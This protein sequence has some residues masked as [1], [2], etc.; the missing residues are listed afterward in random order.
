MISIVCALLIVGGVFCLFVCC[1]VKD[2]DAPPLP[3]SG[4]PMP[5]T[6]TSASSGTAAS[7]K[8]YRQDLLISVEDQ[9]LHADPNLSGGAAAAMV[10]Q[11]TKKSWSP[12]VLEDKTVRKEIMITAKNGHV[13]LGDG[14]N[15]AATTAPC[16]SSSATADKLRRRSIEQH[17]A[18][19]KFDTPRKQIGAL[20]T[21]WRKDEK[22]EKSVRDK[23]A[24]FST[25]AAQLAAAASASADVT[26]AMMSVS[27]MPRKAHSTFALNRSTEN[28]LTLDGPAA[29]RSSL[30]DCAPSTLFKAKAQSVEH[31]D[32]ML[33]SSSSASA[34]ASGSG[35]GSR[36]GSSYDYA[37][38]M[39]DATRAGHSDTARDA[40]AAAAAVPSPSP[41]RV[42]LYMSKAY[43]VENLNH[44]YSP[45]SSYRSEPS[46]PLAKRSQLEAGSGSTAAP[47]ADKTIPASYASLPR[48][49]PP[50]VTRTTSFSGAQCANYED[51]RRTSISSLLE[52][53]K[54]SMSKLRGLIIPEKMA[55]GAVGVGGGQVLHDLPEIKSKQAEQQQPQQQHG[56]S[57]GGQTHVAGAKREPVVPN[58]KHYTSAYQ[59]KH[60]SPAE[61]NTGYRSIFG[62]AGMLRSVSATTPTTTPPP[63]GGSPNQSNR[64]TF[65]KPP[66][67]QPQQENTAA[68]AAYTMPPIKPPRTSLIIAS[69]SSSD[70]QRSYAA[71]DDSDTDS[72]FSSKVSTPPG[73]PVVHAPPSGGKFALTR[74][75]SSETNTSIASST[76]ST[77]TSGSGSQASCSSIGSTPT[78]DM[79]RKISK[80][81]S[82]ESYANRKNILA[83]AKCRSGKDD[84]TTS[85]GGGP[86]P[87]GHRPHQ[88]RRSGAGGIYEDE[89]STDGYD[90]DEMLR[91]RHAPKPKQRTSA[92]NGGGSP[93]SSHRM[94]IQ[95]P[96]NSVPVSQPINYRLVSSAD[97]LVDMVINVASYVEVVTETETDGDS[98]HSSDT[99]SPS[100]VNGQFIDAER[101]ASFE[102]AAAAAAA[103]PLPEPAKPAAKP[104]MLIASV[105]ASTTVTSTAVGAIKQ[106]VAESGSAAVQANDMAKWVRSEA[107]RIIKPEP[108]EAA[109]VHAHT[110]ALPK[111]REPRQPA[112]PLSVSANIQMF[113]KTSNA[114]QPKTP[115]LN[116]S[117]ASS[118]PIKINNGSAAA[119]A[120]QVAGDKLRKSH[121]SVAPNHS[122]IGVKATP[123][124]APFNIVSTSIKPDKSAAAVAV[125]GGQQ[126]HGYH[127]R[128][129][130]L[131]SL[132]SSSSSGISSS[133][134]S[135][136][137]DP[138]PS[139][140][141]QQQSSPSSAGDF[142]SFSSF[143]SN[144]SLITPA[145]LQLI[146]EEADPPLRR[147]EAFVVVLQR[148]SPECSVGVTLAG[149]A[150]Y[151]TKEITVGRRRENR[152]ELK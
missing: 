138:S 83:L 28:L 56:H 70:S 106:S 39:A 50:T 26:D 94:V 126:Q 73:S 24:M 132:A 108:A 116:A 23:I 96:V 38:Y 27:L 76:T 33:S 25:E 150:D 98:K 54:K 78:I 127:E 99:Y 130:S 1:S 105:I 152:R 139:P 53:R 146:I 92:Q 120:Q 49:K 149:G 47:A 69:R 141:Q 67:L 134:A 12:A 45:Y 122:H 133:Q 109:L 62:S 43:S 8:V 9:R 16:S 81:S 102:R 93:S 140:L 124:P 144:H 72:V 128:F 129:S 36:F 145:D 44:N 135:S 2:A 71:L 118:T 100:K 90:E 40:T 113:N 60:S 110:A 32:E 107:T 65:K 51:R 17:D 31:L 48:T 115:N 14:P 10:V 3:K 77:L 101:Q 121:D 142:G 114:E 103:E 57:N 151:E 41:S 84:T 61:L 89:D 88:Q 148:E 112:K 91:L 131:D 111:M 13:V 87:L 19:K 147:A 123:T 68:A 66:V 18:F 42:D 63:S 136:L 7:R 119:S 75:L 29:G 95:A 79:S 5:I 55:V 59:T 74:T 137:L 117:N 125:G 52:Q 82:N 35:S 22:S 4:P 37:A 64:S 6:A 15:A 34:S 104:Q 58:P 86:Q 85:V 143:G 20:P 30:A 80:S 11:T 46:T 97:N 21:N